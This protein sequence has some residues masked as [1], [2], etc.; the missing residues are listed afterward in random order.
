MELKKIRDYSPRKLESFII[1]LGE[2]P[3]RARQVCKWLYQKD[4]TTFDEM[5]DLS[6]ETRDKDRSKWGPDTPPQPPH[7]IVWSGGDLAKFPRGSG[8]HLF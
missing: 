6:F 8:D 7:G 2:K 1:E 5:T 3:Y 4:A